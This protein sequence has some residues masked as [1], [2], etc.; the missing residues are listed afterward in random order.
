M[1]R[2]CQI[3]SILTIRQKKWKWTFRAPWTL[4]KIT[5]VLWKKLSRSISWFTWN[6][7][8]EVE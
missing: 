5:E 1:M 3:Q 6:D 8:R 4:V 2:V 7:Y